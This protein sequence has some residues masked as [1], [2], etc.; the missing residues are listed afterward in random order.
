MNISQF[1][2]CADCGMCENICPKN[3]ISVKEDGFYYRPVVDDS[4]CVDCGLCAGRCP[5]NR[6]AEEN[7]L[8]AAYYAVNRDKETVWKSSSGGVFS[9]LADIVLK[10]NGVVF[11]AGFSSDSRKVVFLSTDETDLDSLRRSKYVESLTGKSFRQIETQ[12]RQ[13][14]RVLFCGTPCQAAGLREYLGKAYDN[15]IICDFLCGGLPSHRMYEDYLSDLENRFHSKVK[16]VNFRPK[17]FGWK[18]Y[19]IKVTFDNGKEYLKQASLDPYFSSFLHRRLSIRDLC[20]ECPFTKSHRS[21][22]TLADFWRY[23]SITGQD[24]DEGISMILVN[25][26]NGLDA[27]ENLKNSVSLDPLS[28]DQVAYVYKPHGLSKGYF[29]KRKAFLDECRL[30]G[31]VSAGEKYC[32]TKG[33]D[34]VKAYLRGISRKRSAKKLKK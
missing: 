8:I 25:T 28:N 1:E 4:L 16:S 23:K 27:V 30:N 29:E 20:A 32:V 5:V 12:L 6:E 31:I 7:E 18:E 21:D 19:A 10:E 3:A 14:R 2:K 33:S 26:K 24:N 34:A 9:A 13:G 22:I 15:L 17:T 11:G